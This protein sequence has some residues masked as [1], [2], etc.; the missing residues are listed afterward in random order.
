MDIYSLYHRG[1]RKVLSIYVTIFF[2]LSGEKGEE[3]DGK[4][5]LPSYLALLYCIIFF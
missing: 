3:S 5:Y 2:S 4:E 1:P